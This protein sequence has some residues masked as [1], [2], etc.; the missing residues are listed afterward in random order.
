[1]RY[2][3]QTERRQTNATVAVGYKFMSENWILC[4]LR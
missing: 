3:R 4:S 1:M 2:K